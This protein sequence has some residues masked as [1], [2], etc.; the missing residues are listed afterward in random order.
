VRPGDLV[1]AVGAADFISCES[2]FRAGRSCPYVAG[3]LCALQVCAHSLFRRSAM[4][5]C[6]ITFQ[7]K[8]KKK[9]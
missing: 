9:R 5:T 4:L 2:H 8:K 3:G 6:S 1:D 7:S